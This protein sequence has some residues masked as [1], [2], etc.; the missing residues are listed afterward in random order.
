MKRM[1][2]VAAVALLVLSITA[3]AGAG[4]RAVADGPPAI[5][6][7]PAAASP[8][9]ALIDL[10]KSLA[11]ALE[12]RE[13][14]ALIQQEVGRQF[15]GDFNVLYRDLA[16]SRLADGSTF[17]GRLAKAA[18]A[19]PGSTRRS[20]AAS[21]ATIDGYAEA[22]PRLQIAVPIHFADWDVDSQVPLVTYVST[23][24]D[25]ADLVEVPAYDAAGRVTLLDAR[26]EPPMP[27]VVV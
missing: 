5:G 19:T 11:V 25:D 22:L 7:R 16:N 17:R 27:V 14:R 26:F 2:V 6:V 23:E 9:A 8:D 10:A 1:L 13:V 3:T 21:L 12:D 24:V 18:A 15:D 20:V 4:A